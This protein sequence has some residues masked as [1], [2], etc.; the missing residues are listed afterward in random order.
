[1]HVWLAE[2]EQPE[3]AVQHLASTLSENELLRARRFYFERDRQHFIVARGLLR[4]IL[5][6]YLALSPAR[7]Q[8]TYGPRGKPSLSASCGGEQL[9]FNVSHSHE[10]A[11][12]AVTRGREIGVDIEF[13]RSLE[14]ADDIARHFFSA[15]ERATLRSLP[16]RLKYQA[17]YNCWTRKE[18]YIKAIGEGLSQPLDE[19]A[20]SLAPG[21]PARLLSVMGKPD[22]VS[23]WTFEALQ[24]PA[25]YAAAL[26]V[27]GAGWQFA[28]W[29]WGEAP[30]AQ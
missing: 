17:F 16:A 1:M 22:E 25:G 11:L 15:H 23:R 2:L 29:K 6:W 7:L 10:L 3:R 9:R 20:V 30:A 12:Y 13:M 26:A 21:E 18:A 5:G 28:C 8:F 27:E 4:T 19:F 14:D 24:P